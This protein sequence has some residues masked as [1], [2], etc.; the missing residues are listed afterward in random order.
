MNPTLTSEIKEQKERERNGE[1]EYKGYTISPDSEYPYSLQ[2]YLYYPTE[3]GIDHDY[4]YDGDGYCYCGNCKWAGSIEEA[5]DM[6]DDF[7][8]EQPVTNM[9]KLNNYTIDNAYS[10]IRQAQDTLDGVLRTMTP[11]TKE[12][13]EVSNYLEQARRWMASYM[14][15]QAEKEAMLQ[16]EKELSLHNAYYALRKPRRENFPTGADGDREW[17]IEFNKWAMDEAMSAP[18]KPGYYRA[19]ND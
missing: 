6:I 1:V 12:L 15:A 2:R 9:L 13:H 8:T 11:T 14:K 7:L 4:D 3:Q 19:N 17:N 10:D 5:K 16:Y 18:N